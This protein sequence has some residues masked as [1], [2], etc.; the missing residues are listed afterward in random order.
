MAA[1]LTRPVDPLVATYVHVNSVRRPGGT[2]VASN[3]F[4]CKLAAPVNNVVAVELLTACIPKTFFNVSA[5]LGNNMFYFSDSSGPYVV[6]VPDGFYSA[7]NLL[8]YLQGQ[9]PGGTGTVTVSSTTGLVTIADTATPFHL[10]GTQPNNI[11][12]LLGFLLPQI[13]TGAATYTGTI[14]LNL[15]KPYNLFITC[16]Q[17]GSSASTTGLLTGFN[18]AISV[19]EGGPGSIVTWKQGQE[20]QSKVVIAKTNFSALNFTLTDDNGTAINLNGG[21]WDALIRCWSEPSGSVRAGIPLP[22]A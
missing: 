20:Y 11:L 3:P 22:F 6:T 19:A 13:Y 17:A 14:V 15:D 4:A 7:T 9:L 12:P 21:D 10:D 8:S 18:W 5:A 1:S 2:A 16:S